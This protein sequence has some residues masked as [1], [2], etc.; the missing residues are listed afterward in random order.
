MLR[1]GGKMDNWFE[2]FRTGK[3]IAADGSERS[4]TEADL[5]KIVA[6]YNPA[7]HEA[8]LVVG[9]PKDNAP[10]YGWVA[11]LRRV[12]DKLQALAK[13]VAPEFAELVKNRQY[14]KRSISLYP[15]LSLRHVGFLGAMPPA[16][17][18]LKD[19]AFSTDDNFITVEYAE[20]KMP[21]SKA[22]DAIKN[23]EEEAKKAVAAV[24]AGSAEEAEALKKRI[25]ELEQ[26]V[27]E[28][29]QVIEKTA[30]ESAEKDAE[31]YCE[32]LVAQGKLLPAQKAEVVKLLKSGSK[33]YSESLKAILSAAPAQVDFAEFA[34][35]G[36][37]GGYKTPN[38]FKGVPVDAERAAM[39]AKA[40]EYMTA[41]KGLTFE[42]AIDKVRGE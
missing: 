2:V 14:P 11:S 6:S 38:K 40:K 28:L 15:D 4:Y 3:H 7:K 30:T 8:P 25:G 13:D 19:I 42:Q 32:S 5:D 22:D 17:K 41:D 31:S 9:H 29:K 18:G 20:D 27:A 21:E 39:Y 26:L 12:G 23:V 36:N 10:A 35:G 33:D 24:Q 34:T 1:I 16:V 37:T